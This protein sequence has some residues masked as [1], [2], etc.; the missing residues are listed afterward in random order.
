VQ[1][2]K[3]EAEGREI[4]RVLGTTRGNRKLAA[5]ELHISYKA[6]SYKIKQYGLSADLE[7]EV[8]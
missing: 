5:A 7:R 8:E 1:T 2:L 4:Q 3:D 6:L